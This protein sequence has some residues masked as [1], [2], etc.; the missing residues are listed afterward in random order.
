MK[1]VSLSVSCGVKLQTIIIYELSDDMC[2][3]N[4]IEIRKCDFDNLEKEALAACECFETQIVRC[5][6]PGIEDWFKQRGYKL[7][8]EIIKGA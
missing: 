5:N 3:L 1:V 8:N 6:D 7:L 4:P 2:D